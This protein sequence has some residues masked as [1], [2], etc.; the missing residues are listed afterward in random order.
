MRGMLN[1]NEIIIVNGILTYKIDMLI[2]QKLA[3]LQGR[4]AVR[5]FHDIIFLLDYYFDTFDQKNWLK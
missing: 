1:D 2:K 5:D 4:T 3:A